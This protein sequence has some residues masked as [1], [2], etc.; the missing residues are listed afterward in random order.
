MV[1]ST[2]SRRATPY[3]PADPLRYAEVRGTATVTEDAGRGYREL[4]PEVTRVV[5]RI[6]PVRV[7]GTLT[8]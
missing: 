1:R 4:P 7:L 6:S 2:G 5:I 8:G 3:D